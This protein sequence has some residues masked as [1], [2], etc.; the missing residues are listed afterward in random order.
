[1]P[2]AVL[3][4]LTALGC[5]F[6]IFVPVFSILPVS[7][8][9]TAAAEAAPRRAEG[10]GAEGNK[11]LS[12]VT[13]AATGSTS[14]AVVSTAATVTSTAVTITSTAIISTAIVNTTTTLI[15]TTTVN[16]THSTGSSDVA[17]QDLDDAVELQGE[18]PGALTAALGAVLG[19]V[20]A[21]AAVLCALA[22]C[23]SPMVRRAMGKRAPGQGRDG[24]N[25]KLQPREKENSGDGSVAV[26]RRKGPGN[27]AVDDGNDDG[28]HGRSSTGRRSD[29]HQGDRETRGA[30]KQ[31]EKSRV[32]NSRND[33]NN[34][35]QDRYKHYYYYYRG[36]GLEEDQSGQ[37]ASPRLFPGHQRRR[38]GQ[39]IR[40][41]ARRARLEWLTRG[42]YDELEG[43]PEESHSDSQD[44]GGSNCL[45][46]IGGGDGRDRGTADRRRRDRDTPPA[47]TAQTI[48]ETLPGIT[49]TSPTTPS[50]GPMNPRQDSTRGEAATSRT[51]PEAGATR[52]E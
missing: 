13:T 12:D 47:L 26:P 2:G 41:A 15:T 37:L 38:Y 48:H 31:K 51:A 29:N 4:A 35:Q 39:V 45:R 21:A 22:H 40:T 20:I 33:N 43:P 44:E 9:T 36:D 30:R 6:P 50:Q 32:G 49:Q 7:G 16:A 42:E 25:E 5:V 1:M 14:T 10:A 28:N 52:V 24:E 3:W 11:T 19:S 34:T 18:F 8:A 27:G 23:W 17:T 46:G